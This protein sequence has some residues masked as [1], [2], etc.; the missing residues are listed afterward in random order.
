[1]ANEYDEKTSAVIAQCKCV[2]HLADTI[3]KV[4]EDKALIF[5]MGEKSSS[6]ADFVGQST[7][8]LMEVLGNIANDMDI[9]TDEDSRF[10]PVFEEAARLWPAATSTHRMGD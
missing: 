1:M 8:R 6:I 10:D 3:A 9:V 4:H 2:A 7:A 5:A